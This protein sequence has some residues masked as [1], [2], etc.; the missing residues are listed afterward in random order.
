MRWNRRS[1]LPDVTRPKLH[2]I[3]YSLNGLMMSPSGALEKMLCNARGEKKGR[4]V[5]LASDLIIGKNVLASILASAIDI[6]W[7]FTVKNIKKNSFTLSIYRRR[8]W[9]DW[10]Q[11]ANRRLILLCS[12][13]IN[14]VWKAAK[15][16]FRHSEFFFILLFIF[17]RAKKSF[18]RNCQGCWGSTTSLEM[19][20]N[21]LQC[22]LNFMRIF[23]FEIDF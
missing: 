9:A 7:P 1:T 12:K 20:E 17:A 3:Y 5:C 16:F 8:W 4:T 2:I 22:D 14:D 23:T 21:V 15:L 13:E 11:K 18:L 6:L 19:T 10:S